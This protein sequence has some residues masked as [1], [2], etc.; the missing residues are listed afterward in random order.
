MIWQIKAIAQISI[1]KINL[2]ENEP[3]PITLF[4]GY[5][6]TPGIRESEVGGVSLK[7]KFRSN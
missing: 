4:V 6:K 1:Q 3:T 5:H 2:K 7:I